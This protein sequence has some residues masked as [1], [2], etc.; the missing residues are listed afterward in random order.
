MAIFDP[1]KLSWNGHDYII[2]PDKVMG[3]IA[4]I[5][6]VITIDELGRYL[7]KK[8]A[9]LA[10]LAQAYASVL[11]YAGATVADEEVYAGMFKANQ[12]QDVISTALST[13]MA[14]MLP[15]DAIE[16]MSGKQSPTKRPH[17]G[18]RDSSKNFTS[19]ASGSAG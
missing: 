4:R 12:T 7:G 10:K 8:T 1:I 15:H 6:D 5:E 9:P 13:L 2:L 19:A 16:Q 3:A 14:M 18:A 11:R 17:K